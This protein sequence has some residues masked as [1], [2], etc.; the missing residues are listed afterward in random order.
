MAEV[1]ESIDIRAPTDRVF[2]ALTD[3]WRGSEWNPAITGIQDITPG[4]VRIGTQWTQSTHIAG[5][6]IQ[7]V[8]RIT[9]LQAPFLG[10]LDVSGDQQGKITTRCAEVPGGTRVTQTLEFVPPGGI[11]GQMAGGFIGN[12]LRREMVRTMERQRSVLEQEFGAERESRT[13]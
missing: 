10:V 3:P 7:L 8:C 9:E 13:S 1:T 12:G 5:R 4:P 6:P 2:A 11:F